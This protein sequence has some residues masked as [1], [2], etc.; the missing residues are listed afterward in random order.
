M[1]DPFHNPFAYFEN[2]FFS[3]ISDAFRKRVI[4]FI[5]L[6]V[7]MKSHSQHT[8]CIF[9]TRLCQAPLR[10]TSTFTQSH[11]CFAEHI[12]LAVIAFYLKISLH[13]GNQYI[14]YYHSL[15]QAIIPKLGV[16]KLK[17][18]KRARQIIDSSSFHLGT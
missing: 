1:S 18:T 4:A 12:L 14:L 10:N 2:V 16:K 6:E 17:S 5:D 13:W 7:V 3:R 8:V 11:C 15:L 9:S